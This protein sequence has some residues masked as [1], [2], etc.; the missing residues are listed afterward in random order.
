LNT[1]TTFILFLATRI[2]A[3][4]A[5]KDANDDNA[6]SSAHFLLSALHAMKATI[7]LAEIYIVQLDVEGIKLADLQENAYASGLEKSV[8]SLIYLPDLIILVES[9]LGRLAD[10]GF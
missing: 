1:Y 5:K 3:L 7:P 10:Q 6:R 8:V 4:A 9:N 2:L